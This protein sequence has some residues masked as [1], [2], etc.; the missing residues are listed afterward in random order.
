VGWLRRLGAREVARQKNKKGRLE[1]VRIFFSAA[2][3][4]YQEQGL[5][6]LK[7]RKAYWRYYSHVSQILDPKQPFHNSR[8]LDRSKHGRATLYSSREL[9]EP[10]TKPSEP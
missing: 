2:L 6:N 9:I 3:W 1:G 4:A 5:K 7:T 10:S 8:L